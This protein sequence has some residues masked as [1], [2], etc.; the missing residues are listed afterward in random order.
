MKNFIIKYKIDGD[1]IEKEFYDI[2]IDYNKCSQVIS[3]E[4]GKDGLS[5]SDTFLKSIDGEFVT[6]QYQGKSRVDNLK[7]FIISPTQINR[8]IK[9]DIIL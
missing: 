5:I 2:T 7:I 1:F 8:N 6:M 3:V 4:S 9:L